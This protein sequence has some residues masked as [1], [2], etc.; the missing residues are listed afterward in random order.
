MRLVKSTKLNV[1][2][3]RNLPPNM[4]NELIYLED[5]IPDCIAA[6]LYA[7][8]PVFNKERRNF[9]DYHPNLIEKIQIKRNKRRRLNHIDDRISFEAER[10]IQF[11]KDYPQFKPLIESIIY[12]NEGLYTVKTVPIDEYLAEN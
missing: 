12:L 3:I 7:N 10:E 9:V 1:D 6:S 5:V 8:D 4:R 2:L 11:I